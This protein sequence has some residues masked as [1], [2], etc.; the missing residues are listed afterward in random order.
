MGGFNNNNAKQDA[1][2][3]RLEQ[4]NRDLVD[5]NKRRQNR[6]Q[7]TRRQRNFGSRRSFF[8]F[9]KKPTIGG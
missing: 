3:E 2:I 1:A 7:A 8:A 6:L 9:D 5:A 4:K